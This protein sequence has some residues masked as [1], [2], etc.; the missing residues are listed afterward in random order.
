MK[1]TVEFAGEGWPKLGEPDYSPFLTPIMASGA[2][3]LFTT[4]AG[5]DFIKLVKSGRGLGLF[6]KITVVGHDLGCI[7]TYYALGKDMPDGIWGGTQYQFWTYKDNPRSEKFYHSVMKKINRPPGLGAPSGYEGTWAIARAAEKAGSTDIEKII[8]A[9]EGMKLDTVVGPVT[10]RKVDHQAMWPF[11]FGRTK[12][13]PDY[14]FPILVDTFR[15][16][17]ETSPQEGEILKAR[18]Q[19]K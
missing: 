15:V 17:N 18:G 3:G 14:A 19:T 5:G 13:T 16:Q 1:P 11:W 12:M 7:N 10:M 6:Q 4:V 2:K 8:D 9:L